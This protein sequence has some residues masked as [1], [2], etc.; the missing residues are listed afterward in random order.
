MQEGI[1][2]MA[3]ACFARNVALKLA[4]PALGLGFLT[5]LAFAPGTEAPA[6]A[7]PDPATC[8]DGL[9]RW[10][11]VHNQSNVTLYYVKSRRSYSND[12]WSDDKLGRVGVP[13]GQWIYLLMDSTNCQCDSDVQITYEADGGGEGATRVYSGVRY[14]A[15]VNEDRPRLIVGN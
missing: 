7:A 11:I 5:G 9:S 3:K 13:A 10:L 4:A 6:A 12:T 2:H 1:L 15:G 14:C 8:N